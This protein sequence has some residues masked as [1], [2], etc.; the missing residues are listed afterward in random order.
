MQGYD[1]GH[2]LIRTPS[3]RFEAIDHST[4]PQGPGQREQGLCHQ[5][6]RDI[7]PHK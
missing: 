6:F 4:V 2:E 1:E 5:V 3:Q 7:R